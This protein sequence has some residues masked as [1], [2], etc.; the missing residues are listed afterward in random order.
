MLTVLIVETC[1]KR[2]ESRN[3]KKEIY[4]KADYLE[5]VSKGYNAV[6]GILEAIK[7]NI[8][9]IRVD[10]TKTPEEI[11]REVLDKLRPVLNN[12]M[13]SIRKV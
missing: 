8:L 11:C 2:I 4:E 13:N 5:S 12:Y 9:F 10:G 3:G 6:F 1:M 7:K